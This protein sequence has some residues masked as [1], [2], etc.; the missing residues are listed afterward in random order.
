MG[1]MDARGKECGFSGEGWAESA[2]PGWRCEWEFD[3]P[4]LFK[5]RPTSCWLGNGNLLCQLLVL[6]FSSVSC[7]LLMTVWS[8]FS[9]VS[10]SGRKLRSTDEKLPDVTVTSSSCELNVVSGLDVYTS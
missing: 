2:S 10:S 1:V 5:A 8:L 4:L 7:L 3:P 6:Q 9:W